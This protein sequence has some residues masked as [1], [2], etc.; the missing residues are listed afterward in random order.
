MIR[1]IR[2]DLPFYAVM[3]VLALSLSTY[4][5]CVHTPPSLSPEAA[6]AFQK[7]QVLKDLDLLRDIAI[8]ANDNGLM[9]EADTRLVVSYHRS[10]IQVM[11]ASDTG[12]KAAVSQGL[13][14]LQTHLP[15]DAE[16]KVHI[17]IALLKAVLQ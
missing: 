11:H 6:A 9:K 2:H 17:Y 13:D 10:A 15:P 16:Q 3:F 1:V 5:A 12:W 8:A 4:S 14:E 7:T